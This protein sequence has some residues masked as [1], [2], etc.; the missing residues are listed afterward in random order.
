MLADQ[1]V[2]TWQLMSFTAEYTERPG[3]TY[4]LGQ[5][6][7]GII[8]YTA[9]GYM[10]AQIM[11]PGRHDYHLLDSDGDDLEQAA[12]AATGYLAYSGK[13]TVDESARTLH[14][15]VEVSLLPAWLGTILIREA[16]FDGNQLTLVADDTF[17]RGMVHSVL[18][19]KRAAPRPQ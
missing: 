17:P 1:V 8:M 5:D 9:D 6:A 10:S 2:G 3:I 7:T 13:Y 15:D 11:R 12:A 4:P 19:W 16:T 14:H 18:V